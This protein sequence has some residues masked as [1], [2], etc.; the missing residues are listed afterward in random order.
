MITRPDQAGISEF[1]RCLL[2]SVA[3]LACV[4]GSPLW[5]AHWGGIDGK[6]ARE[7]IDVDDPIVRGRWAGPLKLCSGF[8]KSIPLTINLSDRPVDRYF[9]LC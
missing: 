7:A 2:A 6:L 3:V 9:M 5:S 4:Q 1:L 8:G